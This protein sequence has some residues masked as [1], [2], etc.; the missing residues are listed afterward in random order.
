MPKKDKT[1]SD[2]Q[3]DKTDTPKKQEATSIFL[4]TEIRDTVKNFLLAWL[5]GQIKIQFRTANEIFQRSKL[6]GTKMD[7]KQASTEEVNS[8]KTFVDIAEI[9]LGTKPSTPEEQQKAIGE[10]FGWILTFRAGGR[11]EGWF[12]ESDLEQRLSRIEK[13]LTVTNNL[14]Q[15]IVDWLWRMRIR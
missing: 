14:V 2:K 12:L 9:C 5:R 11:I 6:E 15:E 13:G 8:K 10:L 1:S 7:F 4:E 3:I